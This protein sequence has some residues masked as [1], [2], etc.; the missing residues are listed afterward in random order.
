MFDDK[1]KLR[2]FILN[3]FVK[4]RGGVL[5]DNTSLTDEGLIDSTGVL[6]IA[7]FIEDVFGI[8]IEDEEIIPA[9]FESVDSLFNYIQSKQARYA[10]A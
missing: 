1:D 9:N 3:N 8:T 10:L 4:D 6:E 2:Q 5:E 7:A